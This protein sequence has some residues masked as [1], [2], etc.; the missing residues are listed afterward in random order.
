MG[1]SAGAISGSL[2]ASGLS[3]REARQAAHS[4]SPP[5]PSRAAAAAPQM[6]RSRQ[7]TQSA[8]PPPQVAAELSRLPPK[9]FLGVS[10]QPHRGLLTLTG[11]IERL[12][13]LLPGE[14]PDLQVDFSCGV[15]SSAG[16]HL[17]LSAGSLPEAVAAS[18][19]VP[20]LFCP[21]DIPGRDDGPFI[22]GGKADRVGLEPWRQHC[23]QNNK[24]VAPLTLVHVIARSTPFSGRDGVRP[25]D[26]VLVVRS[27]K[28]GESL[29][30]LQNFEPQFEA[31]YINATKALRTSGLLAR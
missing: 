8:D 3:P 30:S 4:P 26:G 11:A 12:R 20:L 18:A 19:A 1:T 14:F 28:S 16:R 22:D 6:R 21:V 2:Y 24:P 17:V 7:R 13:E 15:V 9:A 31:S 27:P 25:E 5:R 23:E 10:P 29:L